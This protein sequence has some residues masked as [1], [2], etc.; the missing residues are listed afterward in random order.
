[1]PKCGQMLSDGERLYEKQI[2]IFKQIC[3]NSSIYYVTG[4]LADRVDSGIKNL[5]ANV[6]R[7]NNFAHTNVAYSIG[8]G[9][10][11]IGC[12]EDVLMLM[13]DLYF[14]TKFLQEFVSQASGEQSTVLIDKGDSIHRREI[15]V[16]PNNGIF[17]YEFRTKWSQVC[18]FKTHDTSSFL[19]YSNKN[20]AKRKFCFEI[21]NQMTENDV[22]FDYVAIS[23][24]LRELDRQRDLMHLNKFLEEQ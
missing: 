20:T 22:K 15:G 6:L 8:I 16:N 12:N 14:D 24:C 1:M 5:G 11:E 3:P 13:G 7:N 2:N 21:L 19:N 18:M 4:F 10:N 17:D 23:G 9:L